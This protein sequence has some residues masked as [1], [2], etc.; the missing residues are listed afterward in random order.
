MTKDEVIN[1][2]I[3]A[4]QDFKLEQIFIDR[5]YY[6]E[7]WIILSLCG[8]FRNPSKNNCSTYLE[9]IRE[10]IDELDAYLFDW[11]Y[12]EIDDSYSTS[13]AIKK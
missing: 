5:V 6:D 1:A 3:K 7:D 13:I 9:Q 2:C 4:I 10:L 11:F 8:G 12:N